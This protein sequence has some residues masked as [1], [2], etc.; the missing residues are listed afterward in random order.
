MPEV[1]PNVFSRSRHTW[2]S[3]AFL[4]LCAVAS[5][6]RCWVERG[7]SMYTEQST[8][9]AA[10][11]Q[12]ENNDQTIKINENSLF[13]ARCREPVVKRILW[14]VRGAS[15][16]SRNYMRRQGRDLLLGPRSGQV[17]PTWWRIILAP[18][19][20]HSFPTLHSQGTS[21]TVRRFLYTAAVSLFVSIMSTIN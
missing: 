8:A 6:C 9:A 10:G 7:S 12:P 16:S 15:R 11:Q 5:W 2:D 13:W 20:P 3:Q 19:L 4:E 1:D 14:V 17:E 18:C 21:A